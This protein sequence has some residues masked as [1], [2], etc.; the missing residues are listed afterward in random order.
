M[1]SLLW[2]LCHQLCSSFQALAHQLIFL[3]SL[4]S[5]NLTPPSSF[6]INS[7]ANLTNN[8]PACVYNSEMQEKKKHAK[9]R[10]VKEF[11]S[12]SK[13]LFIYLFI[14]FF[15]TLKLLF[16][17]ITVRGWKK[18]KK[19]VKNIWNPQIPSFSIFGICQDVERFLQDFHHW[20]YCL[21]DVNTFSSARTT[22]SP[23]E[24]ISD[25]I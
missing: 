3:D 11:F 15:V 16:I 12:C 18:R 25:R 10:K 23:M 13:I 21:V 8:D 22:S 7:Y 5:P 19:K 4:P 1:T 24:P 6:L 14:F 9:N 20:A 2:R 17:C